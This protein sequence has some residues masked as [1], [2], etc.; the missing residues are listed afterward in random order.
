MSIIVAWSPRLPFRRNLFC[1]LDNRSGLKKDFSR[2][3]FWII[4]FIFFYQSIGFAQNSFDSSAASIKSGAIELGLAGSMTIVEGNSRAT[5]SARTGFFKSAPRGLWNIETAI[6]F[7][8][9]NSLDWLDWEVLFS[10][11][12]ALKRSSVYPFIGFGGGL[13]QEYL[14]SF[15]QIR[16]RW[17]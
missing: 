13:L 7:S 3:T 2:M 12:S 4:V 15:S 5:I 16:Y 8:R 6:T 11:Q 1:K 10:W 9:V 14:G 17:E